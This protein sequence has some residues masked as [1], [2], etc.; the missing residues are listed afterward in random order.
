MHAGAHGGG[1][2]VGNLGR[3]VLERGV[4]GA[5]KPA[6][7]QFALSRRFVN[8]HDAANF[9]R[10]GSGCAWIAGTVIGIV[11]DFKLW[12]DY[13]QAA[14]A[15]IFFYLAIE[16]DHLA[17]LEFVFQVAAVEPE[18][19][20]R[21]PAL[22][23]D[24]LENGH[25]AGTEQARGSDFGDH[26]GHFARVQLGNGARIEAVFVAERQVIEQIFDGDDALG[27]ESFGEARANS[28]DVLNGSSEV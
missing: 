11:Q 2:G 25:T 6:R 4:N 22:S 13:L 19:F 26:A 27:G 5:A 21:S 28:L 16:S 24:H 12:L 17:E 20:Q 7:G 9:Q 15:G 18:T 10:V 1:N 23:S 3:Q 8:G 14:A